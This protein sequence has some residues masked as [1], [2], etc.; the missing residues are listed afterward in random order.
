[1]HSAN[2]VTACSLQRAV[3]GYKLVPFSA[4]QEPTVVTFTSMLSKAVLATLLPGIA[5]AAPT[6]IS[7]QDFASVDQLKMGAHTLKIV[8]VNPKDEFDGVKLLL[9]SKELARTDG[10]RMKIEYQ[11]RLP[12]SDVVLVSE[13]SGGNGCPANYRFVQVGKDDRVVTT[14]VFGNCSDIPQVTVDGER[15]TVALPAEAGKRIVMQKWTFE[16]GVL[17]EPKR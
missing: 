9:D 10:D 13:Y 7:S 16:K 1:M 15:I 11:F 17:A 4:V 5:L 3:S 8:L 14:K 6:T 2:R 12:T